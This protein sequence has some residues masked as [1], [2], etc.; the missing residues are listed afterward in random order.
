VARQGFIGNLHAAGGFN[1]IRLVRAI[2][3]GAVLTESDQGR[4]R[5][6]I[7]DHS[8]ENFKKDK[9]WDK[10]D[11]RLVVC[12]DILE[13]AGYFPLWTTKTGIMTSRRAGEA[14]LK[15]QTPIRTYS[16]HVPS[17]LRLADHELPLG[18]LPSEVIGTIKTTPKGLDLYNEILVVNDDPNIGRKVWVRNKITNRDNKRSKLHKKGRRRTKKVNNDV[19]DSD[20]TAR[21]V[22]NALADKLSTLNNTVRLT[23]LP[24]PQPEFARETINLYLYNGNGEEIAIG[25][26][27]VHRVEYGFTTSTATMVIDAGR[28]DDAYDV[29]EQ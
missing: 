12:N 6:A 16:A 3:D 24:D 9:E 5:Y 11:N 13:G 29:G 23:V 25:H 15:Q 17:T 28:I 4:R 7:A 22:A 10:D 18:S 26:H 1:K 19:L 14:R 2:L 20:S 21:E 8:S 27:A